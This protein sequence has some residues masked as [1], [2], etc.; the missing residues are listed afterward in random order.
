[1]LDFS[2]E[3]EYWNMKLNTCF[4]VHFHFLFLKPL[5]ALNIATHCSI[6]KVLSM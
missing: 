5:Y 3:E 2:L 4:G 1:M 6:Q